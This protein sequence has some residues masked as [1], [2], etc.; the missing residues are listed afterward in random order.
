MICLCNTQ[1]DEALELVESC[2]PRR[3][4]VSDLSSAAEAAAAFDQ[5][6]LAASSFLPPG[7]VVPA[8]VNTALAS[9]KATPEQKKKQKC[10]KDSL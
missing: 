10:K 6:V 2:Y 7:Y 3:L 5:D 4:A 9:L 1:L 8:H